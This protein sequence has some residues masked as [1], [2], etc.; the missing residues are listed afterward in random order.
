MSLA[1]FKDGND[2]GAGLEICELWSGGPLVYAQSWVSLTLPY[3][4]SK[5]GLCWYAYPALQQ[6]TSCS[7]LCCLWEGV[8]EGVG[9]WLAGAQSTSTDQGRDCEA[10]PIT[11]FH[12]GRPRSHFTSKAWISFLSPPP[13][14]EES[15]CC[16]KLTER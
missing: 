8:E 10:L 11:G 9:P 14:L 13:A 3:L 6:E 12:W 1:H 5:A 16:L 2:A 4:S 15:P 7:H